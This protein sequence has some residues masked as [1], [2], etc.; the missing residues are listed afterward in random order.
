MDL[1]H[2]LRSSFS[3]SMRAKGKV[4]PLRALFSQEERRSSVRLLL[5]V[6]IR[7]ILAG[8]WVGVAASGRAAAAEEASW[9]GDS[10]NLLLGNAE[11]DTPFSL[12][13]FQ[14]ILVDD[15]GI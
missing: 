14:G 6:L 11:I 3:T 8:I 15:R 12:D 2:L 7:A 13:C 1:K 4:S 9:N 5:A 10:S